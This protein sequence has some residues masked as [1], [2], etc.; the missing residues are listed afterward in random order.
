EYSTR[1]WVS[2]PPDTAIRPS[3]PFHA[4]RAP[5]RSS[6][7]PRPLCS[8]RRLARALSML[9][10]EMPT[11]AVTDRLVLVLNDTNAAAARGCTSF[12]P[13]RVDSGAGDLRLST[14][15]CADAVLAAG[16]TVP[17]LLPSMVR[18]EV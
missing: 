17:A 9:T 10:K 11:R 14:P 2:V 18:F 12:A 6:S 7:K 3:I 4:A 15:D 8:D 13:G 5:V 16:G 1:R